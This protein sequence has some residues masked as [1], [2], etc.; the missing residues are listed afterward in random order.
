MFLLETNIG[1]FSDYR[2]LYLEMKSL[3]LEVVT[4]VGKYR[5]S[6]FPKMELTLSEVKEL[7]EA[8]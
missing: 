3:D 7:M 5:D 6:R 1:N 4:V 2:S 8:K